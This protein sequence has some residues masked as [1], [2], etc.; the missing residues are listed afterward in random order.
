MPWTATF[1]ANFEPFDK[2]LEQASTSLGQFEQDTKK[3]ERSLQRMASEFD[4][5][6]LSQQAQT[7]AAAVEK[8][9]GAAKLTESEQ[10]K[11]NATVTEAMAKYKALGTEAPASIQRL[12]RELQDVAKSG[13]LLS[14]SLGQVKTIAAGVF[15]GLTVTGAVQGFQRVATQAFDTAGKLTDL[16][17]Q[18]GIVA[19]SLD[20]MRLAA[21]PAGVEL[22]TVT[23]AVA[24]MSD[25]LVGGDKSAASALKTL[26]LN[27]DTLKQS[28]PD[29]AFLTIVGALGKMPDPMERAKVAFDVF[30][31][32]TKEVLRLTNDEFV[33]NAR[34]GDGWSEDQIQALDDA[35]DAWQRLG[36]TAILWS[37][38]IIA[39]AFS[40]LD[41]M[42]EAA[43]GIG[44]IV[45]GGG[46][47][48]GVGPWTGGLKVATM[49]APGASLSPEDQAKVAAGLK[50]AEDAIKA[51]TGQT[52]RYSD[53]TDT[54]GQ[55]TKTLHDILLDQ[56]GWDAHVAR[57]RAESAALADLAVMSGA[58]AQGL[59]SLAQTRASGSLMGAQ[60]SVPGWTSGLPSGL[61]DQ[62]WTPGISPGLFSPS[63]RTSPR[64]A[65]FSDKYGWNSM[66]GALPGQLLSA[67][68]GGNV[69]GGLG[70]IAGSM[71]GTALGGMFSAMAGSGFLSAGLATTFGALGSALPI[72]GTIAGGLLGKFL[73]G[74]M[75]PSKNARLTQQANAN[76]G[77]TQAGLL[78]QYGSVEQIASMGSAGDAL[79]A[80]W[81]S[82]GQAGEQWFNQLVAAFERQN[83]LLDEQT[84]KQAT[85]NDL[86]AQRAA[87]E[88]SLVPTAATVTGLMQQ[89]GIEI[90]GAGQKVQQLVTTA[91]FEKLIN[92]MQTLERAG[93]D[94]GGMLSGMADEI[95][96]VVQRS[97]KFKTE[98]PE[99]M[100]P[101]I[102]SLAKAGRLTDENGEAIT[103]LSGIKFGAPVETEAQKV[104]KAMDKI[105]DAMQPVVDRLKEIAD[106]L[107]RG[108]PA[109]AQAGADGV[110]AA[111]RD[112]PTGSGSEDSRGYAAGDVVYGTRR[113]WIGEGGQPEIVGPV[114]FMARA[115]A[116]AMAMQGGMAFAGAG[117]PSVVD[118]RIMLH[119]RELGRAIIDVT[120]KAARWA[121]V[122]LPRV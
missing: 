119:E 83:Q 94:T 3:V 40:A 74:L 81:G 86:T 34:E 43:L 29:E 63:S 77:Q 11:L 101:Y 48:S 120:P 85:L 10:R 37:G 69:A 26:G 112:A 62:V 18:T 17:A 114:S 107:A 98:I 93:I 60:A 113:A 46:V 22:D 5:T 67:F 78:K 32:K 91:D 100:R 14:G 38:R 2:Q 35:G 28:K 15:A 92:D 65:S 103:D 57:L 52:I 89:Y 105:T 41:K 118:A 61:G 56:A 1:A 4:G 39:S 84:A 45:N 80:A 121:G 66:K 42:K 31:G 97:L 79:A 55:K 110:D 95:S 64:V 25:K 75:G 88:Q 6:K 12:S 117:G 44:N 109:A 71:G 7:M 30:G 104:A 53:A 72:V 54:A 24:A 116:G 111:F 50:K 90:E 36:D 102:E 33:R 23:N 108:I 47:G 96:G 21:A 106:L 19:S 115:L 76:I 73:G 20:R 59:A 122:R 87:L 8:I 49:G 9:G 13:G 27:L 99:N 70:S 82:K 51:L 16:A 58:A 68:S